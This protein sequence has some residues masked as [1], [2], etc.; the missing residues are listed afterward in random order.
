[1]IVCNYDVRL[2]QLKGGLSNSPVPWPVPNQDKRDGL[3]GNGSSLSSAKSYIT[4]GGKK[5]TI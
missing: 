5:L 1:M 4:L 3:E 2:G